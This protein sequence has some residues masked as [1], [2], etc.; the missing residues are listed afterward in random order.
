[1]GI[2]EVEVTPAEV[3]AARALIK[4]SGN[5]KVSDKVNEAL[6]LIAGAEARSVE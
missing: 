4:H 2:R 1:M 5:D 3:A 6:V